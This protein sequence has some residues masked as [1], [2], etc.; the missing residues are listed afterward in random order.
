[1]TNNLAFILVSIMFAIILF[2]LFILIVELSFYNAPN[3]KFHNDEIDVSDVNFQYRNI[4]KE[5]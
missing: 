4:L 1:M 3:L 5:S 2:V